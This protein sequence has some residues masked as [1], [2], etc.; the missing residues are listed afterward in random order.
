MKEPVSH[1]VVLAS[2]AEVGDGKSVDV[3]KHFRSNGHD[4]AEL[5]TVTDSK[6]QIQFYLQPDISGHTPP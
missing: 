2:P 3:A 1:V 6:S 4:A 5:C